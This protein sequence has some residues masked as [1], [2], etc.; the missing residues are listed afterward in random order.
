MLKAFMTASTSYLGAAFL[1]AA[2]CIKNTILWVIAIAEDPT[3]ARRNDV[4]I[5]RY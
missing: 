2:K 3:T 1:A 5:G 4:A